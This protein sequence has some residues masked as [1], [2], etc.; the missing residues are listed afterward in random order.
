M[1][2]LYGSE[3]WVL[4]L[5]MQRVVGGFHH[6]VVHRLMGRQPRK[7]QDGGWVY[8]HIEDAMTEA[9]L[10]EVETVRIPVSS[11][12][13]EVRTDTSGPYALVKA[14]TIFP[15]SAHTHDT[16]VTRTLYTSHTRLTSTFYAPTLCAQ[17]TRHAQ[18]LQSIIYALTIYAP[19]YAHNQCQR[20]MC[21]IYAPNLRVQPMS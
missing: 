20:I 16:Q 12:Y 7:G 2:L 1:V 19:I 10:Q 15:E 5:R 6:R 13:F 11:P 3:T 8:P 17:F 9:G 18:D 14:R 4:T 21:T